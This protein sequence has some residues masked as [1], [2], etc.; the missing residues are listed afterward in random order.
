[1]TPE[2][3][4]KI[5]RVLEAAVALSPAQRESFL[6]AAA[7]E[8]SDLR[9][10]LDS[11]L[12]RDRSD[13]FLRDPAI[14]ASD[15]LRLLQEGPP[16][17][18]SRP[19]LGH[20][21]GHEVLDDRFETGPLLGEG[22][23]GQVFRGRD[24]LTGEAVA[25]KRLKPE[26]I[27]RQPELVERFEREG[28]ALRRLNHP[29]IV[30]VLAVPRVEGALHIVMELVDGG[31]LSD[32][33][34]EDPRPSIENVLSIA[35]E[36][37]D[38]LARAHHLE[39]I[40]RDLKPANVLL[41]RERTPRLTDFGIARFGSSTFTATGAIVGTFGYMSPEVLDGAAA[42][43]P[44]DIWSFGVLLYEMLTGRRPFAAEAP[45]AV[46]RAILSQHPP[47]IASLRPDA[48]PQLTQLVSQMLE[49]SPSSRI[50]S[51]RSVAAK[52]EA[53]RRG[54]VVDDSEFPTGVPAD[55]IAKGGPRPRIPT[56]ATP[57]V[58][59][60]GELASLHQRL[61]QQETRILTI[62]GAGGMGKTRLALELA[63][64][65][66]LTYPDG[67]FYVPL[68]SI[69]TTELLVT[70]MGEGSGYRFA[71]SETAEVQLSNY[72][73]EKRLLLVIDNFEHLLEGAP[74][75][76]RIVATA[77]RVQILVTSRER[78]NLRCEEVFTIEGFEA[79][80][81]SAVELFVQSA[82]L[83]PLDTR[84]LQNVEEICRLLHGMPLAIELAAGWLPVLPPKEILAELQKDIDF[85]ESDL[86]D[87]PE[88]HRSLRAVF[89]SSWTHLNSGE[90][91]SMAAL[92]VFRGSFTRD[93]ADAVAGASLRTLTHLVNKSLLKRST[94]GR[95]EQHELLRQYAEAKLE[96]R[97][98]ARAREAH[99]RYFARLA[100]EQANRFR[101]EAQSAALRA[102]EA[103]ADGIRTAWDWCLE[104]GDWSTLSLLLEGVDRFHYVKGLFQLGA[105]IFREAAAVI[106]QEQADFNTEVLRAKLVSRQG[107]FLFQLG[108]Y[109]KA[110]SLLETSLL[111]LRAADSRGEVAYCLQNL[112]DVA[113]SQGNFTESEKLAR[114]G[115]SISKCMGDRAGMGTAL[116]NLGVVFYHQQGYEEAEKLFQESL[117]VSR[118]AGD[119]WGIGFALNNLGVLAHDLERF[120]QAEECYRESLALCEE[121]GDT[122]GV[123]AALVNLGRVRSEMGDLTSAGALSNQALKHALELGD[124]WTT[125]ACLLNLGEIARAEGDLEHATRSFVLG[126]RK[127]HEIHASSLILE[128]LLGLGEVAGSVGDLRRA[129]TYVIPILDHPAADRETL[130]KAERLRVA[131]QERLADEHDGQV[132]DSVEALTEKILTDYANVD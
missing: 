64:R 52:I 7:K 24:R 118:A 98:R 85:L 25:I 37:A 13:S 83:H 36:L 30:K 62:L 66:E 127:A 88:R 100:E 29:N 117:S 103:E 18:D 86:R 69:S 129:L 34:R 3:W 75:L 126:L 81:K 79:S 84:E 60:E 74:L 89:D 65:S 48:S 132:T 41:T 122:H 43:P 123:A 17:S 22:G 39:I 93:A 47:P 104:N 10:E 73:R 42:G 4:Q 49:K 102:L 113:A 124:P 26:L 97:D 116:N 120:A 68:S 44:A 6:Q 19:I 94:A 28:E 112:A 125:A 27:A 50:S 108:E 114:E 82:R 15:V 76:A 55:S 111:V 105:G 38:A 11:L 90:R 101:G 32:L 115:L 119:R 95:Y 40:H 5:R 63:R 8:D 20:G 23:M 35:L 51:M 33:L 107:R 54:T 99:A 58:G 12:A 128:G 77:P 53:I 70:A 96:S 92:S 46:L 121:L 110:R 91:Q 57:F 2:R 78:L 59:R 131:F 1:M 16:D 109:A 72:L 80:E 87:L 71:G 9:S 106:T 31:S 21:S 130:A 56:Q 45:G 61:E 14:R 67:A